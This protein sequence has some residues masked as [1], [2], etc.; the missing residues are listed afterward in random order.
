MR[1]NPYTY[2][3]DCEGKTILEFILGILDRFIRSDES[4]VAQDFG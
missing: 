1:H 4:V 3:D 2:A